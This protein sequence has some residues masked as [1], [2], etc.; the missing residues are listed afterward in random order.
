[1]GCLPPTVKRDWRNGGWLM[2]R[3][4]ILI[5]SAMLVAPAGAAQQGVH[6]A[7]ESVAPIH[8]R[9]TSEHALTSSSPRSLHIVF[10]EE[11]FDDLELLADTLQVETVR[12][13][14]GVTQGDSLLV[15][16]AWQPP[17]DISTSN[18]VKYS[19]CP[20]ATVLL[21]HNHP[22]AGDIEPEYSC[23]L[24]RID[25][26]EAIR[27]LAPPIQMVQVTGG[28]ACWWTRAQ[29]AAH[30]DGPVMLPLPRQSRGRFHLWND[31]SCESVPGRVVGA[32]QALS[33]GPRPRR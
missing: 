19:R 24:S 12:C 3:A 9:A 14:I 30:A 8:D 1:M 22:W 25:I 20:V 26:Q 28:M 6:S 15:D 4:T 11:V 18:S 17:I 5:L 32:R 31:F 29:V 23:Y 16:L 33:A 7:V 21:W 2:K 27:S 10:S 13:L